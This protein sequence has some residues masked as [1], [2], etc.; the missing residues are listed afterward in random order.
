MAARQVNGNPVPT[1]CI[2]S[3]DR[4]ARSSSAWRRYIIRVNVGDPAT[5]VEMHGTLD[6]FVDASGQ[7]SRC[8]WESGAYPGR[9][10]GIAG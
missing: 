5:R 8:W 3:T 9:S 7:R 4:Q 2:P 10:V 6:N 1:I